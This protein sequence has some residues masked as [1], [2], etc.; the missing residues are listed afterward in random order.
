MEY[1]RLGRTD[2]S[3][4]VVGFG[5]ISIGSSESLKEMLTVGK[6]MGINH[7]DTA[8]GYPKSEERLGMALSE[9]RQDFH[10]TSR[11]KS[12]GY[13]QVKQD[14]A[15]SLEDL[16]TDYIDVY[17]VHELGDQEDLDRV[18]RDDGAVR[19]LQ[20]AK[21]EGKIRFTG[22]SSHH[23]DSAAK[24]LATGLFD[25]LVL[26]FSPVEYSTRHLQ[27]LKICKDLD[28]GVT[29]MK[30]MS[31]GNFV[32]NVAGNISFILQHDIT[33]VIPGMGSIEELKENALAGSNLHILDLEE[34]DS[35]IAAAEE[36][37]ESFCRR[38]GYCLPCEQDVPIPAIMMSDAYIKG[39]KGAAFMFGGKA[40]LAHF[41][42]AVDRCTQ[43][44]E[45]AARCPYQ[46]AIPDLLPEK[47]AYFE[48]VWT[49]NFEKG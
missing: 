20:E 30:P 37:G 7:V 31:G 14:I 34:L 27:L 17:Q 42:S 21:K 45:C 6:E 2:L 49:E 28:V 43:C 25:T 5:A 36:L 38:C 41:K 15:D 1:R 9:N 48:K 46:L 33:A 12:R 32:H 24:A 16:Q 10:I 8:R 29:A 4:S 19:M 39:N 47:V 23:L 13:E 18:L 3:V 44:G 11:T 40:G 35:L 22:V 26:P